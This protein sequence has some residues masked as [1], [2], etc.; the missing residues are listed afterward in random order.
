[1]QRVT[2]LHLI[3]ASLAVQ[4]V[5]DNVIGHDELVQLLLQVIVLQRQQVCMVL[6]RVQLLLVAVAG[7]EQ[8]FVTL[9]DGFKLVGER[10]ELVVTL[11]VGAFC[12]LN[13]QVELA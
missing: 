10:L 8:R 5:P 6:Q 9:S 13:V 4:A 2:V 1:M 11:H 3:D 12:P 7:L